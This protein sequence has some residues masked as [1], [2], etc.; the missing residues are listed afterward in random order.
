MKA[1][2]CCQILKRLILPSRRFPQAN[3][4][5]DMGVPADVDG[6]GGGFSDAINGRNFARIATLL[7]RI[8]AECSS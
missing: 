4:D 2:S 7:S 8:A 5:V 6:K 1:G 3:R